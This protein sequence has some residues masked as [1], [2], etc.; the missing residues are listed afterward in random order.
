MIGILRWMIE[1][2][3]ID[4]YM[5]VSLMSRYLVGPRTGHLLQVLHIFSFL[6]INQ[7][8]DIFYDSTKLNITEPTTLPQERETSCHNHENYVSRCH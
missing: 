8:M 7:C 3:R 6:K 2:S 5:E 4:I 1:L